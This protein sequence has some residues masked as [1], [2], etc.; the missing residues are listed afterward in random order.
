MEE[1]GFLT[2]GERAAQQHTRLR[3]LGRAIVDLELNRGRMTA[4]DAQAFYRDQVG[5]PDEAARAEV[6]K[7]AMFP[8]TAVMYWLGTDAIHRLRADEERRLGAAFS[9]RRF[10]DAF[11]GYGAL[12]VNVIADLIKEEG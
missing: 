5:M 6:V 3:L 8:A 10:H 12:T 1:V 11:L 9:L 2:P 4:Q 7:N